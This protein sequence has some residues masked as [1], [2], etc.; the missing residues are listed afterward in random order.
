MKTYKLARG[1]PELPPLP[2]RFRVR[3][4]V[5]EW[6][7][8]GRLEDGEPVPSERELAERL[9]VGRSA[10]RS[11]LELLQREGLLVEAADGRRV[12][13]MPAP[14][15]SS[16]AESLK[17]MLSS[18]VVVLT[19]HPEPNLKHRQPGWVEQLVQGAIH[20]LRIEGLDVLA[21]HP[22]RLTGSGF[23]RFKSVVP[24]GV[25]L[26]EAVGLRGDYGPSLRLLRERGAA[27]V[28]YGYSETSDFDRVYSDHT[29]GMYELTSWMLR[30][31]RRR[32]AMSWPTVSELPYW[33]HMRRKG[34]EQAMAD[35]GLQPLPTLFIPKVS[36]DSP[37][38][39]EQFEF[40][41][42]Q[43]VGFYMDLLKGDAALDALLC[44]TD[45][46]VFYAA[47]ALRACGVRPGDDVM[48]G[49]YDHYAAECEERAWCP[50]VP[51]VTMDKQNWFMGEEMVRL[52]QERVAGRL[53]PEPQVRVVP[54]TLVETPVKS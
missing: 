19:P 40:G 11:A 37:I 48:L 46:G 38:S 20:G 4:V 36:E 54:P 43:Q 8:S 21:M 49:G 18:T 51:A 7:A 47:A 31:G 2:P 30:R 13:R 5:R 45:R 25:L 23:E 34:Y 6:I 26:P 53:P 16:E 24:M 27:V 42:R 35:A 39:A 15:S 50:D 17:D 22:D 52:L 32:V 14:G 10:I 12:V 33:Y 28:V 44:H 29:R 9:G 41:W 1:T 3:A